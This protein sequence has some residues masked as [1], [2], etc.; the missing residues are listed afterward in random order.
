MGME[1]GRQRGTV[2][3]P[4]VSQIEVQILYLDG[5][6]HPQSREQNHIK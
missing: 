6:R 1:E 2:V 3:S 5:I 4:K